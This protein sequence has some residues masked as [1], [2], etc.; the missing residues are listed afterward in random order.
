M[1][2]ATGWRL[3]FV[4]VALSFFVFPRQTF[5]QNAGSAGPAAKPAVSLPLIDLAGYQRIVARHKGQP[6]LV[7]FWATWCE[8]CREEYPMIVKLA[9]K[10]EPKGLTVIGVDMD[11]NADMN[12]VRHFLEQSQPDFLNYRQKPGIDVDAFYQGANPDWRGTMPET[13]F[14][15]RDG[16]IAVSFTGEKTQ[17][18]FERAILTILAKFH[19]QNSIRGTHGADTAHAPVPGN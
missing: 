8:P 10:Y 2:T 11:D 17:G 18:D 15:G 9:T 19:S 14:Y 12:L 13:I 1:R 5:A 4:F 16:Q 3:T 6:M 7:T